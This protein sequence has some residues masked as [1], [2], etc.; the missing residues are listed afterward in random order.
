MRK[1]HEH[2][3]R[4]GETPRLSEKALLNL[5][6][7]HH[8]IENYLKRLAQEEGDPYLIAPFCERLSELLA[9]SAVRA[10]AGD[11]A[12]LPDMW[13]NGFAVNQRGRYQV[14]NVNQSAQELHDRSSGKRTLSKKARKAI[15]KAQNERWARYRA[16]K[17]ADRARWRKSKQGQR[18]VADP[19][20]TA[21]GKPRKRILTPAQLAAMRANAVKAHAANRKKK[22]APMS[23]EQ[24]ARI[25]A[26][27][28]AA[29]AAKAAGAA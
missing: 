14:R 5:G 17:D 13:Q 6:H 29:F 28:K 27:M 16:R 7:H 15:S 26:S 25:S 10:V 3:T 2:S 11:P 9:D 20:L 1:K 24:R 4:A 19:N 21:A 22:H 23:A 12:L 18:R 8:S